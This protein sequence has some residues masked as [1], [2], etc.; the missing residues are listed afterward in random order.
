M[1]KKNEG[2]EGYACVLV[3]KLQMYSVGQY[4]EKHLDTKK[5]TYLVST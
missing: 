5:A 4:L 1:Y 3:I 2:G